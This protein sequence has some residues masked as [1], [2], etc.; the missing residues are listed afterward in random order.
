MFLCLNY[1]KP[2]VAEFST[3]Y[4][5][6]VKNRIYSRVYKKK[7]A[8]KRQI[9]E[10]ELDKARGVNQS[11]DLH[12]IIES[13]ADRFESGS[14]LKLDVASAIKKLCTE[15]EKEILNLA[16]LGYTNKE[17]GQKLNVTGTRV[18]QILSHT[19][20]KLKHYCKEANLC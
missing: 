14:D 11:C 18:Q 16:A 12:R 2:Q 15:R 17:I 6:H 4:V 19:R 9:I 13:R 1:Y 10:E 8:I 3:F 7:S 20:G 5:I